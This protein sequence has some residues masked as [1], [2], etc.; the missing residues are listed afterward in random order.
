MIELPHHE[1]ICFFTSGGHGAAAWTMQRVDDTSYFARTS[2]GERQHA[3]ELGRHHVARGHSM[4]VDQAQALLGVPLLHQ[5]RR[6]AEMQGVGRPHQHGGVIERRTRQVD[7]VVE[8]LDAEEH[9]EHGVERTEIRRVHLGHRPPH[10]LG[11]AGG[12][13][14][15]VHRHAG[16]TTRRSGGRLVRGELVEGPEP[17]DVADGE[18]PVLRQG[19]LRTPSHRGRRRSPRGRRGPQPPSRRRCRRSRGRRDGG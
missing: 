1:I 17:G 2:L 11:S 9:H 5:H 7:V 13:R 19:D 4:L 16:G 6:V 15:V 12:A 3:V 10:S 14:R 18:P 8:R